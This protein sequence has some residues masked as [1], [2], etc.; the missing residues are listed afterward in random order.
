MMAHTALDRAAQVARH[1]AEN[2]CPVVVHIDTSVPEEVY[3]QF[4]ATLSDIKHISFSKRHRCEWGTWGMVAAAQSAATEMLQNW[5]DIDHVLL[6]SGAC[7]PLRPINELIEYLESYPETDFIESATLDDVTWTIGGLSTERFTL[8]FPFAWRRHRRLFDRY[9]D[10]QRRL[11]VRRTLPKGLMPHLGSQWWCLTGQTLTSVLNDPNRPKYD[12][13]FKRVWIPDE[14]YFQTLARLHSKHIESR[15]LTLAKFDFQGKPH[16]FYDDHLEILRR[17]DCFMARKIW[18]Q[19]NALYDTFLGDPKALAKHNAEPKPRKI[20]RLFESATTRRTQGRVGLVMQSRYPGSTGEKTA[21]PYSVF[22]GFSD[23]FNDFEEW[24][25]ASTGC[26]VHGHLF[27]NIAAE[28]EG[29]RDTYKG[30]LSTNPLLRSRHPESFLRNLIW[31]QKDEHTC[32]QFNARDA[33]RINWFIAE[34]PNAEVWTITGAWSV[35]LFQKWKE[36]VNFGYLRK[37]A[38]RLQKAENKH[39]EALRWYGTPSRVH[40]CSMEEFVETPIDIMQAIINSIG[41]RALRRITEIPD[42]VDLEG[43]G[44]FI[45]RLKNDGMHPHLVGEFSATEVKNED[46]ETTPSRARV[47]G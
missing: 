2:G 24:L 20:E 45:Q 44:M 46:M 19:A 21:A 42:I 39:I 23:I 47:T 1:W 6:S 33:Q 27:S 34:D 25:A 29:R 35:D 5:P 7:L 3:S 41:P 8:H 43:F 36:G 22:E 12:R 4:A 26:P 15:S 40:I 14:S 38:A 30:C 11:G 10:L 9:V 16:V 13:Y 32:F 37:E 17:S 18:P 31:T 28:F